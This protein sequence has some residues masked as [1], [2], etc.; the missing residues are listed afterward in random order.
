M[1]WGLLVSLRFRLGHRLF[2]G[3]NHDQLHHLH[4]IHS[5]GGTGW[6]SP[7][8]GHREFQKLAPKTSKN[9]A[10]NLMVFFFKNASCDKKNLQNL[11][12]ED[13][14]AGLVKASFSFVPCWASWEC[15][16][17]IYLYVTPDTLLEAELGSACILDGYPH[18][19]YHRKGKF[20]LANPWQNYSCKAVK[21]S[22]V[23]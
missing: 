15:S 19:M 21:L 5:A 22:T 16:F 18:P 8:L 2:S 23:H 3:T 7:F 12:W 20:Q 14:G 1:L 17:H 4:W 6:K 9:M 13:E 11:D 10:G